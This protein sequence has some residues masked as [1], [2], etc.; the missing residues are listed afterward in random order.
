MADLVERSI[1]VIAEGQAPSGAYVASPTYPTYMYAW[2]RDGTFIARAA[3]LSGAGG[4]AMRFYHWACGQVA[5]RAGAIERCL[6]AVS[7]RQEP[8]EADLLDT[9]YTLTGQPGHEEWPNFQLDGFGTL[10]WGIAWQLRRERQ[11]LPAAWRPAVRLLAR[12][13]AALWQHPNH[14]CWEEHPDKIAVSTLAALH[15]GLRASATLLEADDEANVLARETADLMRSFAL[16]RGVRGGH[17]IKHV[18]GEDAVD[19]SLLWA[20]LPF[21]EHALL[22]PH[23]PLMTATVSRIEADLVGPGGGVYRYLADTYYGGGQW[24]LLTALLGQ[25][26]AATGQQ[27]SALHCLHVVESHADANGLLPEQWISAV[28]SPAHVQ[29]WVER[30]GPVARPL[31]WSH[32]EHLALRTALDSRE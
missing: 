10:L 12:Y 6:Q 11:E 3:A 5:G 26:Y 19:A 25:Y 30:W 2:F 14:D 24:V 20:C 21:G 23:D 27:A 18:D 16:A 29:Q 7:E 13:L 32:A 1:A 9:R 15:A 31:L 4:S 28:R 17:L 8:A 22:A